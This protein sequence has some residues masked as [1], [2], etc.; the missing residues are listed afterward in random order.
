MVYESLSYQAKWWTKNE[1]PSESVEWGVWKL[2][3]VCIP[4]PLNL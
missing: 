1:L 2:L 4:I 3:G